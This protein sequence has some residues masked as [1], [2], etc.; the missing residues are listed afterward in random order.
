MIL[1]IGMLVIL[2]NVNAFTFAKRP[3]QRFLNYNVEKRLVLLPDSKISDMDS[4]II[5][6][7][8]TCLYDKLLSD[9]DPKSNQMVYDDSDDDSNVLTKRKPWGG[10]E[11]LRVKKEEINIER[12][13][14]HL[15]DIL[16][17]KSP[18]EIASVLTI[19]KSIL[20]SKQQ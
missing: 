10:E 6:R 8:Y 12:D 9:W 1:L 15:G 3:A 11:T 18:T 2:S 13:S 16:D 5:M 7:M 19:L 14:C 17:N 4:E 20:K